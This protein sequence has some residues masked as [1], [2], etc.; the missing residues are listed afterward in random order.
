MQDNDYVHKILFVGLLP[1]GQA[2]FLSGLNNVEHFP[3]HILPSIHKRAYFSDAFGFTQEEVR[4]LIGNSTLKNIN[5]RNLSSHY[6]GYQ[7][8]I[9]TNIYNPHSIISFLTK[10]IIEDYWINSGPGKTLVGCLKKC[11][12]GIKEKLQNLFYS[13]YSTENDKL[14]IE[15]KLMLC[16]RYDIL[17][18]DLL[19][20]DVI[21]TLLYY[22]G[23]LTAKIDGANARLK[24]EV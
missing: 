13:F 11:E 16:L 3:M 12:Q 20:L 1:I 8:S 23:Y 4:A 15:V 18:N 7:T 5:L 14:F 21:C 22:S 19:E 10:G 9:G 2:S 17:K 24:G 6:N